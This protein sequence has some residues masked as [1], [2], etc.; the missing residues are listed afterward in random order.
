MVGNE[1]ELPAPVR[2]SDPLLSPLNQ[3]IG[4]GKEGEFLLLLEEH[5]VCLKGRSRMAVTR[6][7]RD[8]KVVAV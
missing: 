1:T 6:R 5:E 2:G 8:G 7:K 3:Q 4:L